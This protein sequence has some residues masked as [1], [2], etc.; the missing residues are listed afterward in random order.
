MDLQ[1]IDYSRYYLKW[2]NDTDEHYESFVKYYERT[3]QIYLPPN[4]D[5]EILDVGCGMGLALYALKKMGYTNIF[6]IDVSKEQISFCKKKDIPAQFVEDTKTFLSAHTGKFDCVIS[7]DVIEHIPTDLQLEF[8]R[9]IFQS[10]KPGGIFICTVPNANSSLA[11]RWRHNDFTHTSSFTE[12]SLDFLLF[13]AGFKDIKIYP[14]EFMTMPRYPFI[15]RKSVLLWLFFRFF[16]AFR[17]LEMIA[18]LGK[19]GKAVP[20]SL[21]ILGVAKLN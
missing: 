2:H 18:E 20:L 10:L 6:G 15:L 5:A 21:N 19:E 7:L 8:V 17:R 1:A 11:P 13:N 9:L 16:R 3:L 4:K 14:I 12:H